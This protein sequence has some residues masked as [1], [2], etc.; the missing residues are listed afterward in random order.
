MRCLLTLLLAVFTLNASADIIYVDRNNDPILNNGNSWNTAYRSISKACFYSNPGDEIWVAGGD[1]TD[2]A[3]ENWSPEL[4]D[5]YPSYH[6]GEILYERNSNA[7]IDFDIYGGFNGTETMRSQ[8]NPQLNPCFIAGGRSFSGSN[9]S[10]PSNIVDGFVFRDSFE[11]TANVTVR[12]CRFQESPNDDLI[13]YT[14]F[15][16]ESEPENPSIIIEDCEFLFTEITT[17]NNHPNTFIEYINCRFQGLT[18]IEL[19]NFKLFRNSTFTRCTFKNN[20]SNEFAENCFF[21]SCLFDGNILEAE[22]QN[23]VAYDCVFLNCT[24]VNNWLYNTFFGT[25]FNNCIFVDNPKIDNDGWFPVFH[26]DSTTVNY[27]LHDA[28]LNPPGNTNIEGDPGFVDPNGDYRLTECALAINQGLGNAGGGLDLDGFPRVMNGQIDLGC[29]EYQDAFSERVYVN[30]NAT[31]NNSGTSWSNAFTDLQDAL[32]LSCN[33]SEI[34]VAAG[35]YKPVP[36]IGSDRTVSFEIPP[37]VE[38][39]GGFEGDESFIWQ[40]DPEVNPTWLSGAIGIPFN[41]SDNSYNVVTFLSGDEESVVDGFFIGGGNADGTG[42]DSRGGGLYAENATGAIRNCTFTG[43]SAVNGGAVCIRG[44]EGFLIEDCSFDDNTATS[45]GGALRT[46][47]LSGVPTNVEVRRCEFINNFAP[48][49]GAAGI[50][51]DVIFSNSL[52]YNNAASFFGD[53]L[54]SRSGSTLGVYNCTFYA[55][56]DDAVYNNGDLTMRNCMIFSHT[57][58][59]V[60]NTGTQDIQFTL[61]G[62]NL[63]GNGNQSVSNPWFM[64]VATGDFRLQPQSPAVNFGNY[65]AESGDLDLDGNNRLIGGAVDAGAYEEPTGCANVH[66]LCINAHH[67]ELQ[68]SDDASFSHNWECATNFGLSDPLCGTVARDVWV[69]FEMPASGAAISVSNGSGA[70]VILQTFIGTCNSLSANA[71][72]DQVGVD[73]GEYME[74]TG[75]NQGTMVYVRVG[76]VTD[77]DD[78][79]TLFVLPFSCGVVDDI[80]VLSGSTCG[81]YQNV[82]TYQRQVVI[83]YNDA[84][85]DGQIVLGGP[86]FPNEQYVQITGS[87]QTVALLYVPSD[88]Q[89]QTLE[90][91]IISPTVDGCTRTFEDILPGYCCTPANDNCFGATALQMN[92]SLNDV[93]SCSTW[94]DWIPAECILGA[95]RDNWYT[96]VAPPSG[97]VVIDT[98]II[99]SINGNFNIR[100]TVFAGTCSN[101][102]VLNCANDLNAGGNESSLTTGLTPGE[103]YYLRVSGFDTQQGTYRVDINEYDFENCPADFNQNGSIE[104]GDLLFLLSNLGCTGI[105][106]A[107]LNQSGL[108]GVDDLL[109]FLS[110]FGSDC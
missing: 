65:T 86:N 18:E 4:I 7:N 108:V 24:L 76:T 110:V 8:R 33:R 56:G 61:S 13:F 85:Q 45:E 103:T 83:Y 106:D 102:T 78:T 73:G 17:L 68:G 30:I 54:R 57:S 84:P 15:D 38:L 70:D 42:S 87:P 40:Q 88:G 19:S 32:D 20:T 21:T 49:S 16:H 11:M 25:T 101:L 105:C 28:S 23:D 95:G 64:N 50:D 3:D 31:G 59:P 69:T 80:D 100:H 90:V 96:F 94:L 92:S 79:F 26:P 62:A 91:S 51:G 74:L 29:Y 46:M 60:E 107:D 93:L 35:T 44:S 10:T 55:N 97:A 12:N 53:G 43:N 34:W 39:Y 99:E 5:F 22:N 52:I 81:S 6:K 72:S 36:G 82:P 104:S 1:Y 75:I 109:E 63:P 67:I 37:G 77:V 58:F 47:N 41:T 9:N 14:W 27:M 2:W 98:D 48:Y 71:C 66:D 89:D